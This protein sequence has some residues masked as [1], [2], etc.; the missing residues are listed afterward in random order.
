MSRSKSSPASSARQQ[1]ACCNRLIICC[2]NLCFWEK[3]CFGLTEGDETLKNIVKNTLFETST[4]NKNIMKTNVLAQRE[5]PLESTVQKHRKIER[6][7]VAFVI[8]KTCVWGK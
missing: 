1:R 8:V 2:K 3:L 4:K 6:F 7:L 5:V